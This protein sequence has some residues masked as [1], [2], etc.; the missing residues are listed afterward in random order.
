MSPS[1]SLSWCRR[2]VA[3]DPG[4]SLQP[5]LNA[6]AALSPCRHYRWS[7]Q[8]QW[9]PGLPPLVFIGLNP[10]R[11]DAERDDPTLR[12]IV[13]FARQWGFGSVTVLNLF[14]RISPSPALLKRAADP[15]GPDN[16]LWLQRA[17]NGQAAA[18]W[19]GWG[20]LGA[21]RGRDRQVLALL[22]QALVAEPRLANRLLG[23]GLT[24]Q[25]QPRHPLYAAAAL[26][27]Q[28]LALAQSCGHGPLCGHHAD[29]PW[30]APRVV[31]PS[32]CI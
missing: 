21:W 25:G 8:R 24:A 4:V 5:F 27:P 1:L 28:R 2:R 17:L 32:T 16:D 18:I 11:A 6:E 14:A 31:M 7:L 10:S 20:N 12:R 9:Q 3:A 29:G 26:Q 13:G 19:L 23:L 30:P 15:V 22:Q